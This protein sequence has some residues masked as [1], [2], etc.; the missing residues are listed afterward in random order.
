[1]ANNTL[2]YEKIEKSA[3]A[4]KKAIKIFT[5]SALTFWAILVLFPNVFIAIP[6]FLFPAVF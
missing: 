3:A 4:R 1:M 6:K 5:Y 2:D